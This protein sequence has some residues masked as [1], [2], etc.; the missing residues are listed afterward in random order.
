MSLKIV[1]HI[2]FF[3]QNDTTIVLNKYIDK[4]LQ[5][6]RGAFEKNKF[7]RLGLAD[8]HIEVRKVSPTNHIF[9]WMY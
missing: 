2:F 6:F 1:N 8:A 7:N 3:R 9:E 4:G 5:T